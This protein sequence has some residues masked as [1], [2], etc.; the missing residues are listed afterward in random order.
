MNKIK[1]RNYKPHEGQQAFH[2]A[3]SYLYRYVAMI[4]GIRGGKT[5][6]GAREAGKQAWNSKAPKNAVFGIIAPTF[7]M[8]DRTTWREFREAMRPLI[9][10]DIE[11][12]KIFVLKNGREVHGF[13]AENPDKIRNATFCGFWCDEARE[14][15]NFKELWKVLIGRTLSTG[16]KGFITT[17]PNSFDDIHDI[18]IQNKTEG[19]GTVRFTTYENTHLDKLAIDE[20]GRQYDEKFMQQ[21]LLGQFVIFE[22]AVYYTF[23]RTQNAGDLAFK[24]AQY[25]PNKPLRLCCDFNVSP[26]AWV[27]LQ[28]GI[29]AETKLK[30]VYCIDEIYLKNSNTVDACLEFKNRYPNH[31]QGLILYGDATG[32]ARH[33]DSNITNWKII[34]SELGRYGITTRVPTS[35]PAER[36]RINSVNGLICNSQKQRRTFVNPDK[37]K[38]LIRDFEQVSFIEGSTRIDK[39]K[40][41]ALT[42]PSDAFGYMAEQE[43]SLNRSRIEGLKI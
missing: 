16:G 20:L 33:T 21:E 32:H 35:N 8:L 22:G 37:C 18:F 39:N 43:F 24:L 31:K 38:H 9:L 17:S 13:S 5:W 1:F 2:Y 4:C 34:E 6:A 27:I 36:D 11:S 40:D 41:F 12:K 7:H 3:I 19:Y 10:D 23:D 25:D 28:F 30:E 26:M 29:N 15:K 42:H 14:A